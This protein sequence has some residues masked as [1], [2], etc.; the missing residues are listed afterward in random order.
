MHSANWTELMTRYAIN[1]RR[2]GLLDGLLEALRSLKASGCVAAYIDGSL[3]TDKE[4]PEDFDACWAADGVDPQRLDPEL[5]DFS[6]GRAAQK[7]RYGGELFP[8]EIAAEPFGT[9]FLDY[10]Q[11]DRDGEPKGIIA[12]AL[13]ELP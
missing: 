2:R 1:T 3:V 11:R 4:Y 12:I 9:T 13:G 7:A 6:D 10:F 8:A 5:L